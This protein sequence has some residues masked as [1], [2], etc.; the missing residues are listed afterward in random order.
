HE[1]TCSLVLLLAA[2]LLR[3]GCRAAHADGFPPRWVPA[4]PV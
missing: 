2:G 1:S 3:T 4:H